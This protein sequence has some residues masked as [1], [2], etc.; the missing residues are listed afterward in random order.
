M[1]AETKHCFLCNRPI[2]P[3]NSEAYHDARVCLD[4]CREV[5]DELDEERIDEV[6]RN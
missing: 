6:R 5:D 2:M 1:H 4:C 3:E